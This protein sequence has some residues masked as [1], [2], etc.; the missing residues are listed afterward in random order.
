MGPNLG[1]VGVKV[2]VLRKRKVGEEGEG[3]KGNGGGLSK[4]RLLDG[5]DGGGRGG[6]LFCRRRIPVFV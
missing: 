5:N 3:G 1:L 4:L 6:W 2:R